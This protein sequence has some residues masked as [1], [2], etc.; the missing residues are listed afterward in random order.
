MVGQFSMPIDI[1]VPIVL[2]TPAKYPG[3][4]MKISPAEATFDGNLPKACG[5]ENHF[6]F[7]VFDQSTSSMRE[8]VRITGGPQEKMGIEQ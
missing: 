1:V 7:R 8:T 5:A 4:D 6:V 3:I 2:Q